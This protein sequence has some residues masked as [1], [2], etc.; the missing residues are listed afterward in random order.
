VNVSKQ[1]GFSLIE[2]M[3]VV[4]IVGVF[5]AIGLPAYRE[6]QLRAGRAEGKSTLLEVASMQERFFSANNSYSTEAD[7]LSTPT[8]TTL[9]STNGDYA[10]TVAAC[11]TGTIA[12]CFVATAAPQGPQADDACGNLTLTDTGVRGAAGGTQD[13]CWAR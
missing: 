13:E 12:N 11:G 4:G 2:I 5:V 1:R 3:I 10:V 9:F 7:P 8:V 6:S